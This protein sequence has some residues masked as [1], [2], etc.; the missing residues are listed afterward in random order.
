MYTELTIKQAYENGYADRDNE[1]VYCRDCIHYKVPNRTY[2]KDAL[3]C[4]RS[5]YTKV[6][7]EDYC[8]FGE[9]KHK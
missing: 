1:I 6:L 4:C 7:P 2:Y 3:M 9:R 5:A 8:S